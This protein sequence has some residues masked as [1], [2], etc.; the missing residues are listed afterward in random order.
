MCFVELSLFLSR[1]LFQ[2]IE[3]ERTSAIAIVLGQCSKQIHVVVY[4]FS[5]A[6]V[7]ICRW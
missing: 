3:Y 7:L 6:E 5:N 2:Q 1:S 4:L